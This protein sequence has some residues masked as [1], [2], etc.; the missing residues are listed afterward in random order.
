MRHRLLF[1]SGL[2]RELSS[3]LLADAPLEAAAFGFA[4][5]VRTPEGALRLLVHDYTVVGRDDY[6][7]RSESSIDLPPAVVNAAMKKAAAE[8][9]AIV[10]IHTHPNFAPTPSSRDLNGESLLAPAFLR[11]VPGAPILR[12][13]ISPEG[14]SS[15]LLGTTDGEAYVGVSAVGEQLRPLGREAISAIDVRFSRQAQ[16][17]GAIGQAAIAAT[18]L[19]IVGLGGTGSVVAQQLALLGVR[20]FELLDPDRIEESNL[21]R[22]VGATSSDIGRSKVD[23]ASAHIRHINPSAAVRALQVD[24]RHTESARILLDCDFLF[25]CTDSQG[26]RAVLTQLAY[27]Y[28]LPMIDLGVAIQVVGTEVSHISG[29]VQMIGPELPCLLCGGVLDA[30]AVRR[31]LLSDAARAADPYI[32]GARV[33]QPAVISINSA[34]ASMAV[35]MFLAAMTEVPIRTR[36]QRLY[37]ESGRVSPTVVEQQ[38]GCPNCSPQGALGKGDTWPPPGINK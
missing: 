11:R 3:R 19:G 12:L 30:E 7:A 1:P 17:F 22:V 35:T 2:F 5:N 16:A 23:V 20:S 4:R 8:G 21:N 6:S 34:A 33:E 18:R 37:L 27:Q 25:C 36:Y 15:A 31:D 29:R 13:I 26:S 10:L 24:V 14:V 9:S 28:L 32:Q 38:P